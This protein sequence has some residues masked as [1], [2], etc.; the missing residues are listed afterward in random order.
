MTDRLTAEQREHFRSEGWLLLRGFYDL[1][2]DIEPVQRGIHAVIG[3]YG[4]RIE[5]FD[6]APP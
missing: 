5:F 4:M 6:E 3:D 2:G 1:A